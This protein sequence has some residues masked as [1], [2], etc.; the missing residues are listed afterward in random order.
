MRAR[1]VRARS[2]ARGTVLVA[3]ALA[4][5]SRGPAVPPAT[6]Q[7]QAPGTTITW[8]LDQPPTAYN[9]NTPDGDTPAT[10][11]VLNGVLG[12]FWRF[13]PDGTAERNGDFGTYQKISNDP[14]TIRYTIDRRAVWS[15]G[16]AIDCDDVALAWLANSG[17]TGPQGFASVGV[18][19]LKDM[20]RPKCQDGDK[21]VTV[22]YR[23][24]TA[25]WATAFGPGAG[26]LMPAHAS[27][28]MP[29][30]GGRYGNRGFR[31]LLIRDTSIGRLDGLHA[32]H[33]R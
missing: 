24:P 32:A 29:G 3:A 10:T 2:L 9:P 26:W 1:T 4:A 12:A 7:A 20:N 33:F 19:R 11:A 21:V 27:C 16:A 28:G 18:G 8:A 25:D 5:C 17:V 31:F 14:L 23:T 6:A 15:D 22:S 13:R 30:E